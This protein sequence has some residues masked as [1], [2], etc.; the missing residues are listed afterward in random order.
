MNSAD[1]FRQA[2]LSPAEH[3]GNLCA[4]AAI[5]ARFQQQQKPAMLFTSQ[6]KPRISFA[7]LTYKQVW[8]IVHIS[9][10]HPVPTEGQTN[11]EHSVRGLSECPN[12][13][14]K[15]ELLERSE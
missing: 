4:K 13:V 7:G 15:G 12:L 3:D 11:P 9:V 5:V 2:R 8:H 10:Y 14:W 6:G 1:G